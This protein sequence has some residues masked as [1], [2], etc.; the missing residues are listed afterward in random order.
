MDEH[1]STLEKHKDITSRSD[2][3]APH[4]KATGILGRIRRHHKEERL[5]LAELKRLKVDDGT[6]K[7]FDSTLEVVY[8]EEGI[9]ILT[10]LNI[11]LDMPSSGPGRQ[12]SFKKKKSSIININSGVTSP[13]N[14]N[15]HPQSVVQ[16]M[17]IDGSSIDNDFYA[18]QQLGKFFKDSRTYYFK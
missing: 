16:D 4:K 8:R 13:I 17:I 14:I 9:L 3:S 2:I 1:A 5:T 6:I 18:M 12:N 15:E 7:S 10:F 11:I